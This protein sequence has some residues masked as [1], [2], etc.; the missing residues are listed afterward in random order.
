MA[1]VY[2]NTAIYLN[3]S[4]VFTNTT[5]VCAMRGAGRPEAS[6]IIERIVD[7]AAAEMKIDPA[8]LR[9]R[10]L[11]PANAFPWNTGFVFTYDC[12]DFQTNQAAAER[13][14]AWS[15][16]ENRRAEAKAHGKLRGLGMAHVI[17]VAAGVRD[18]M[19]ELRFDAS[20]GALTI[21]VG[22]HNHG[23]GHET[24]FRQVIAS[25]LG[26]STRAPCG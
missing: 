22:T 15:T 13:L 10:N 24:T 9:R 1:G 2:A 7:I 4:G 25:T 17:E 5:P 11:I 8:E 12:G 21:V 23:Q 16:F 14:S 26:A 20:F 19:A 3:V 18:E 6:Y